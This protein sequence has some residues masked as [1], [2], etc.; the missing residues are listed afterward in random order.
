VELFAGL[1]TIWDV[2]AMQGLQSPQGA[3]GKSAAPEGGRKLGRG[4]FRFRMGTDADLAPCARLVHDAFPTSRRLPEIWARIRRGY[5]TTFGVVEDLELGFPESI[6]GFGLSV[7]L[8]DAFADELAREPRPYVSARLYERLEAGEPLLLTREELARANTRGGLNVLSLHPGL[9]LYDFSHPRAVEALRVFSAGFL[10]FHAG[11]RLKSVA[12]EVFG[13]EAA[14]YMS[15]GG[16][17]RVPYVPMDLDA[18]MQALPEPQAPG[19]YVLRRDWG[20]GAGAINPLTQ[21]FDPPAPRIGFAPSEQRLLERALLGEGD[22]VIAA[23]FGVSVNA[24]KRT[25]RSIFERTAR[26][27]PFILPREEEEQSWS[28]SGRGQEK[29]RPLLDYLRNHMEEL[30]PTV[31]P[32]AV[33][34][35]RGL[36]IRSS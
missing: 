21:L 19:F 17:R 16:F 28:P 32:Q 3:V 15:G 29:R 30:R 8:S 31:R 24:V 11:Y 35:P 1:T 9:K 6:E 18:R 33:S 23:S 10:F 25:W 26:K 36:P 14:A 5:A 2:V 34:A 13:S 4:A 22:L 20:S 27:A 7:F 12:G